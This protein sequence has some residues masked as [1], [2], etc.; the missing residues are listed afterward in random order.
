[1]SYALF[2]DDQQIS[3]TF[4]TAKEVWD[5]A[6]SA[7]LVEYY[8]EDGKHRRTLAERYKVKKVQAS[9]SRL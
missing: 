1:M 4:A 8:E 3:K 6:N 7:G 2:S 5:H 9:P